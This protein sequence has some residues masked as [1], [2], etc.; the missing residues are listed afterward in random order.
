[1]E[2]KK[3]KNLLAKVN[4]VF[5]G[6]TLKNVHQFRKFLEEF[7]YF[8]KIMNIKI[9]LLERFQMHEKKRIF[10]YVSAICIHIYLA[11]LNTTQTRCSRGCSKNTFVINSFGEWV[12]L[13]H[14]IFK[15]S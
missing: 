14:Q 7:F 5:S 4:L 15:I 3:T 10:L 8:N 1:M 2:E 9:Y 11:L 6:K 13:F 12:S